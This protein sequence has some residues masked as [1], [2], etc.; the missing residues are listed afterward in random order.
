MKYLEF[1]GYKQSSKFEKQYILHSVQLQMDT[2]K[3][4]IHASTLI[5]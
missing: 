5:T 1:V 2:V 3:S 4:W